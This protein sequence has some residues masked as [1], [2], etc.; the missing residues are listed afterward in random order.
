MNGEVSVYALALERVANFSRRFAIGTS[1]DIRDR[2]RRDPG[3]R[4]NLRLLEPGEVP[5]SGKK[6][7]LRQCRWA[8]SSSMPSPPKSRD[9]ALRCAWKSGEQ[10]LLAAR[11]GATTR[12]GTPCRSPAVTGRRRCR[13]HGGAPGSGG[14]KGRRNGNYKH[15]RDGLPVAPPMPIECLEQ[16]SLQLEQLDSVA[17]ID[18]DEVL[19][20]MALAL[21][22]KAQTR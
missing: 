22:Q 7:P 18:V 21:A 11:C 12:S 17:S 5:P 3:E 1:L 9:V 4:G 10:L 20:H 8:A 15:G 14:P 6:P 16:F 2:R 19:G 13:M